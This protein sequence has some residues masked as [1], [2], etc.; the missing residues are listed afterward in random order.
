M[1][2]SELSFSAQPTVHRLALARSAPTV[3]VFEKLGMRNLWAGGDRSP[4]QLEA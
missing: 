1:T 3:M 4:G 2:K